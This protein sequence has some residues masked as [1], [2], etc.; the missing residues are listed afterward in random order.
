MNLDRV[1]FL[2]TQLLEGSEH[3]PFYDHNILEYIND[4]VILPLEQVEFIL[5]V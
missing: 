1:L 2:A 4:E 3:M 5:H